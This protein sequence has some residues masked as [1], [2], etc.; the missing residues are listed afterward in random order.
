MDKM[1][2]RVAAVVLAGGLSG[3]VAGGALAQSVDC[4]DPQTQMAFNLCAQQDWQAE[5]ARLNAEYKRAMTRAKDYDAEAYEGLAGAA[6]ALKTAQRAWIAFR[7]GNCAAEAFT[8]KG[9]TAE[10]Q[11]Y[12]GCMA[13]MTAARS[14]ELALWLSY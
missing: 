6:A 13:A 14:E 9:G 4:N 12:Y 5:D 1:T 8:M 7:D 10:S 2:A 11:V 3:M